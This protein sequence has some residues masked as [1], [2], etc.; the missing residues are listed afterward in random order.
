MAYTFFRHICITS[1]D[2][3]N[4]RVLWSIAEDARHLWCFAGTSSILASLDIWDL[5]GLTASLPVFQEASSH[6]VIASVNMRRLSGSGAPPFTVS[7][8]DCR[9]HNLFLGGLLRLEFGHD[10]TA[11]GDQNSV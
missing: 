9:V 5:L 7:S 2:E 4:E 11:P 1:K 3:L 8:M 10:L 6:V